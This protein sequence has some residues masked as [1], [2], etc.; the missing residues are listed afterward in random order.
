MPGFAALSEQHLCCCTARE[1]S[2][3]WGI[4]PIANAP[5]TEPSVPC[6]ARVRGERSIRSTQAPDFLEI[7]LE[8]SSRRLP[9]D[10]FG[11]P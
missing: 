8:G 6:L 10:T 1:S 3:L 7:N 11:Y 5:P 4:V 9:G 2:R